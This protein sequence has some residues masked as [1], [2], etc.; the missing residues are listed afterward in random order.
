METVSRSHPLW[1]SDTQCCGAGPSAGG[2]AG[3]LCPITRRWLLE[4][5]TVPFPQ[6]RHD[7]YAAHAFHACSAAIAA[8]WLFPFSPAFDCNKTPAM[9]WSAATSSATILSSYNK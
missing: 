9:S 7:G 5:G 4:R 3:P 2:R 8:F 6:Q 1:P